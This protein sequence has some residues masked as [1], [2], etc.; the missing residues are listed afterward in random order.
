V[1]SFVN[2][3]MCTSS[4]DE[5]KAKRGVDPHPNLHGSDNDKADPKNPVDDPSGTSDP[6]VVFGGA[7]TGTAAVNPTSESAA[8]TATAAQTT[9]LLVDFLA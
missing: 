7:L 9:A 3:Y 1:I 8:G 4:C 6:A 5:A 2:G